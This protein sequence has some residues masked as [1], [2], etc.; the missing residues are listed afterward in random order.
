MEIERKF[1]V[2]NI[3][4]SLNNLKFSK[5]GQGYISINPVIR[6]RQLDDSYY[7]TVKSKGL[8]CREEL[9]LEITFDEFNALK[10]KINYN[11]IFKYRYYIP[12]KFCSKLIYIK[13]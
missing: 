9:E 1:L 4:F 2:N 10:T 8:M 5:I 7:L 6:V 12:P 11:L 3:P 13:V